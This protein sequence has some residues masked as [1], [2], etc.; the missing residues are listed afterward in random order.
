MKAAKFC[1]GF[2]N[3]SHFH[4][5]CPLSVETGAVGVDAV[6][7]DAAKVGVVEVGVTSVCAVGVVIVVEVVAD[8]SSSLVAY[9][10]SQTLWFREA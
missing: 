7:V 3:G 6:E 5:C 8:I 4:C 1:H 9:E 2:E 10:R